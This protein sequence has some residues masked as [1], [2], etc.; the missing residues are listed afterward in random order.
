MR[1]LAASWQLNPS[2]TTPPPWKTNPDAFLDPPYSLRPKYLFSLMGTM[3]P[4]ARWMR[5]GLPHCPSFCEIFMQRL[6][7]SWTPQQHLKLYRTVRCRFLASFDPDE[8]PQHF[9]D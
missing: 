8:E 9:K 6:A 7:P 3:V 4:P 5:P 2:A 1:E